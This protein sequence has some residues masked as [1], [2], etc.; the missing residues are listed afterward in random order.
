[1]SWDKSQNSDKNQGTKGSSIKKL[2][3][4]ML[5]SLKSELNN[6][7]TELENLKTSFNELI[8]GLEDGF[9]IYDQ[10]DRLLS[11]NSAFKKQFGEGGKFLEIGETYQTITTRFAKSGIIP[12]IEGK[13]EEFVASLVEKRR[14]EEGID[15]I[16]QNHEGQWIRQRDK[17]DNKGNLIGLRT[18][19]T[20]LKQSEEELRKIT[21][22]FTGAINSMVQGVLIFENEKLQFINASAPDLLRIPKDEFNLGC[23][24]EEFFVTLQAHGHYTNDETS[25]Q[26]NLKLL[27]DKEK[28]QVERETHYGQHLR[29]DIIT[30]DAFTILT[31]TDVTDAKKR[32]TEIEFAKTE[33]ELTLSR[34]EKIAGAMAQG[35]IMFEQQKV[36]FFNNQAMDI[37][38]I[39]D[40]VLFEE[41]TFENF[42][43]LQMQVNNHDENSEEQDYISQHLQ[44]ISAGIPYQLERNTK[45]GKTVRIDGVPDRENNTLT[46]TLTDIT[47][48]KQRELELDR[49]KEEAVRMSKIQAAWTNAMIPG[50][51][52]FDE[53]K[54]SYL[55]P[56]TL[57]LLGAED[58]LFEV[59]MPIDEVIKRQATLGD[60]SYGV[61]GDEYQEKLKQDIKEGKAY[62]F[63]RRMKNGKILRVEGVHTPSNGLVVSYTDITEEKNREVQLEN[64]TKMAESAERAKSEFLANMSHEIRTPMNGVMGM[65]EL[66][67]STELDPKQKMFTDVIV[68]SGAS[69]LTII[70]DILDFSKIDAGQM[71]LDPA[72][73]VLSDS[74][75]DVATLVSSKVAEKDLELIV[76]VDPKLPEMFVGDVGRIRQITTNLVGNAVK[77]TEKGHIFINIEKDQTAPK[78]DESISIKFSI[79]DTGI[80]IPE[81]KCNQVFKKFSQADTSATRKHEGT[82]LGLSIS[83]SLVELMGG[84]IGVKSEVG[85]GSTFW[86]TIDLPVHQECIQRNVI[87][88]DMSNA[89]IL[90]IDDNQVNRAIL[91]EQMNAWNF[92]GAATSSGREGLEVMRAVVQ[93]NLDL[94]LVILDYQMPEMT[95]AEVLEIMRSDEKLKDIPVLMLTSVDSSQTNQ[96]LAQLGAEANLTKPTRSS[97]LLETILQVIANKRANVKTDIAASKRVQN[98][99]KS[100]SSKGSLLKSDKQLDI[101]VAED[102]E[103]NQIV[104]QQILEETELNFKIVENGALAFAS[105]K[106]LK[107]KLILMDV[108][109][110]EMNGKEATQAIRNFERTTQSK[111]VPIVGVTAHALKGDMEACIDAG[112]DDYLS[113]PVSPNKLKLKIEQWLKI[114]LP[115]QKSA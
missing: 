14:S 70:N 55:N 44:A 63:E 9:V 98:Y 12:G 37:L 40:D 21:Q 3:A 24:Y 54:L 89:R 2:S 4:Q 51:I 61:S 68:K 66:L 20:H 28:Q 71:E 38:E 81:E 65:A 45:A 15:K 49:A 100:V 102:N 105:Y 1:M 77:F 16:F 17:R 58:N 6:A 113:K 107:P 31:Y 76:R 56:R 108:S 93:N 73:F 91:T 59:G 46:L 53:N 8:E 41:Q 78:N 26:R 34:Q 69:L 42:L 83:S 94:D 60:F 79:E 101:L 103:V 75:E 97:I 86:F 27:R 35:I 106:A 22:M 19:V 95:G 80:G 43:S 39:G 7:Q 114:K 99:S 48:L 25:I 30:N 64:A 112:M 10:E 84:H 96:K 74:I 82:G 23:S 29:V 109:M 92:D 11:Y 111:R 85:K 50:L 104:F 5:D 115:E 47:T 62:N 67:A 88:G 13:E 90:I 33:T 32:Q 72:P 18:N 52:I 57:E 87:P 36:V 110:P